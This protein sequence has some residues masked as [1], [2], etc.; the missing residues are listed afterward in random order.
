M[1]VFDMMETVLVK[2]L[3]F[4]PTFTLRFVARTIFVGTYM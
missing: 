4:P 2:R 3:K 1:P